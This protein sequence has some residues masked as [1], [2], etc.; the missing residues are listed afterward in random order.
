MQ[1]YNENL[2]MKDNYICFESFGTVLLHQNTEWDVIQEA[3]PFWN[4][5]LLALVD[6]A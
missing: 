4:I 1:G 2:S 5:S 3:N 6:A